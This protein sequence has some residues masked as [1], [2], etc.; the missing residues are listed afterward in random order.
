MPAPAAADLFDG[1]VTIGAKSLSSPRRLRS[2]TVLHSHPAAPL[3]KKRRSGSRTGL[4]R[5]AEEPDHSSDEDEDGMG[6]S[7]RRG[8]RFHDADSTWAPRP[9]RR[10]IPPKPQGAP[11]LLQGHALKPTPSTAFREDLAPLPLVHSGVSDL[12]DATL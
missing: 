9:A 6:S 1:E 7:W 4:Q 10:G 12:L 3:S 2:G 8:Q 11:V 5:L